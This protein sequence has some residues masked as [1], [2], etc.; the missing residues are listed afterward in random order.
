MET[1]FLVI[2][3]GAGLDYGILRSWRPPSW[4]RTITKTTATV[5]II[6]WAMLLDAPSLVIV[7][8]GFSAIGDFCG[9]RGA[10]NW[11]VLSTT[12]FFAVHAIYMIEYITLA[13]RE[14]VAAGP[15]ILLGAFGIA[16]VIAICW[17]VFA[18]HWLVS[19]IYAI[20][21][22]SQFALGQMVGGAMTIIAYTTTL[23]YISGVLLGLETFLLRES[24]RFR[25]ITSPMIWCTYLMSQ[26]L[27]VIALT[28]FAAR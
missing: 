17:R 26:I 14:L 18:Q 10:I 1:L 23:F 24:S 7:A 28:D 25:R 12:A 20:I 13:N 19:L 9:S 3:I 22:L 21:I 15:P 6:I 4:E 2:G 27:T 11:L 8:L 16:C 5:A